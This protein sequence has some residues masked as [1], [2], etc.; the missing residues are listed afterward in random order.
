MSRKFWKGLIISSI[1]AFMFW[2]L[3]YVVCV[4][5]EECVGCIPCEKWCAYQCPTKTH[6]EDC[7]SNC[8][9][10]CEGNREC[11]HKFGVPYIPVGFV[12]V[13]VTCVED[14]TPAEGIDVVIGHK[15]LNIF[16]KGKTNEIGNR[17]FMVT[18]GVFKIYVGDDEETVVVPGMFIP[19]FK[20][21]KYEC[22]P[23]L[24]TTTI[25]IGCTTCPTTS[26]TIL[27][28]TTS[29]FTTTIARVTTTSLPFTTT[30]HTTSTVKEDTTTTSSSVETTSV[31]PVTST[32]VTTS[33][34]E[35]TTT[36]PE[37]TTTVDELTTTTIEEPSTTTTHKPCSTTTSCRR[38]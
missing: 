26:T 33:I 37:T 18:P 15:Y 32:V 1:F 5:A 22:Q 3:F 28:L 14:D 38:R 20:D 24:T 25:C 35:E 29:I 12:R 4:R 16:K 19:I 8:M 27:P 34:T 2:Y 31:L 7:Y 6:N 23:P 11:K 21:F 9:D 10:D 17:W 13:N 30:I 36:I